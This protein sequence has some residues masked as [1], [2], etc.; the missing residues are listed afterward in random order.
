M[1]KK[2][3]FWLTL[4]ISVC[5]IGEAMG[6][7]YWSWVTENDPQKY[8]TL[9]YGYGTD[10][11]KG[12]PIRDSLF[13]GNFL[14]PKLVGPGGP[15]DLSP[16]GLQAWVYYTKAPLTAPGRYFVLTENQPS[17]WSRTATDN[18]HKPKNEVRN[19]VSCTQFVY[20][21][22]YVLTLGTPEGTDYTKPQGLKLEIVPESDPA[23][24]KEDQPFKVKI[25]FEDKPL[26]KAEINAFPA[27]FSKDNEAYA[28]SARANDDGVVEI[29]PLK[30]GVW[31]AKVVKTENHADPK[32]CD[33]VQYYTSLTFTVESAAKAEEAV[34][35]APA[36][37]PPAPPAPGAPAPPAPPAPAPPAPP[38]S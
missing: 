11:P 38:A 16:D 18:V 21:G 13:A 10:F 36:G 2:Y 15:V 27:G 12:D 32:V 23:L 1:M 31:L 17:Y 7:D 33:K 9:V 8:A 5:F 26:P 34:S 30:T 14:P 19:A 29:I 20:T 4:S 6:A 35:A 24:I 28:F 25:L 37:A 3:V 22:K